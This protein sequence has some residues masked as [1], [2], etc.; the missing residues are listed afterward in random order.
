MLNFIK[1]FFSV[2]IEM[3]VWFVFFNLLIRGITF[4]D[5]WILKNPFILGMNTS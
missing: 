4:I 1:S 3:I 5:L 2:S